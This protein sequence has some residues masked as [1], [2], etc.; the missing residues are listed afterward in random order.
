MSI[1]HWF[2]QPTSAAKIASILNGLCIRKAEWKTVRGMFGRR[3][4]ILTKPG[5]EIEAA[6]GTTPAKVVVHAKAIHMGMTVMATAVDTDATRKAA[7]AFTAAGILVRY[8][9]DQLGL[10]VGRGRAPEQYKQRADD[11]Q[12]CGWIRERMPH[13]YTETP[14]AGLSQTTA[15]TVALAEA[16]AKGA[17]AEAVKTVRSTFDTLAGVRAL[18]DTAT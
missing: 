16:R 17:Q 5:Y 4:R 12:W 15:E 7:E 2:G 11:V 13:W 3:E 10:V 14:P 8:T 6:S 9:A 1:D 18:L